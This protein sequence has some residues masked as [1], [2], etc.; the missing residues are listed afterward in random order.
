MEKQVVLITGT[1]CVGKTTVSRLL[2]V[3]LDALC[4]NLTELAEKEMLDKRQ[5]K[6]RNTK[7]INETEMR[8]TLKEIISKT[9]KSSI[10]IDGHFAPA[11]T[12][13]AAVTKV[14]VLRRNPIE[15]KQLMEERGYKDQKLWENLSSEILD[16]CLVEA[17]EAHGKDKVCELDITGQTAEN[18]AKDIFEVMQN[19]KSCSVAC[20][21]WLGMLETQGVLEQY[22]RC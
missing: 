22:L 2:A 17:L 4:V 5:D 6:K 7:I 1:P 18:V 13:K 3:D 11:V 12:P 15:L 10:I 8:K 20:V 9:E 14:F 19:R 21:D 16:V